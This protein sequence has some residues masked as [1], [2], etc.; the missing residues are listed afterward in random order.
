MRFLV[1]SALTGQWWVSHILIW[2][3]VFNIYLY[4]YISAFG[5]FGC[6][7]SIQRIKDCSIFYPRGLP[8]SMA[9]L[10]SQRRDPA[11]SCVRNW[12]MFNSAVGLQECTH[13]LGLGCYPVLSEHTFTLKSDV[14]MDPALLAF[15][16]SQDDENSLAFSPG[17]GRHEHSSCVTSWEVGTAHL[18]SRSCPEVA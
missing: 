14:Q 15:L 16:L 9:G 7:W 18:S 3:I 2:M 17:Q 12:W 4:I 5:Y 8:W 13:C 6:I 11:A 10:G 1:W